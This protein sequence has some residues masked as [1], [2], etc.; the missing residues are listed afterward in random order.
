MTTEPFNWRDILNLGEI[1]LILVIVWLDFLMLLD[2]RAN[3]KLYET[4]FLERS[5]WYSQRNKKRPP[6]GTPTSPE[7]VL[8]DEVIR[9][10]N[11]EGGN[12]ETT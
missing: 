1:G 12:D 9:Q 11:L 10:E 7:V 6:S 4:F 2:G 5:K 8:L 3:R